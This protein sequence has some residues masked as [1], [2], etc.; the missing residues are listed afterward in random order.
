MSAA[1]RDEVRAFLA[2]ELRAGTF[3]PDVNAWMDG[4]DPAFSRK[5]GE[6]GWIGMT[7]PPDLG[8]GGRSG[9]D[10]FLVTEELLVAGAPVAAHWFADRQVGPQLLRF[11]TREQQEHYLPAIARG[12]CFFAVGMSEPQAGS[13]LAAV[14]TTAVPVDGG[15]LVNGRKLWTSH[16]D[17]DDFMI[18]LCRTSPGHASRHEGLTQLIIDLRAGGVR[19]DPIPGLDGVAHFAEVVLV[20]VFVPEDAVVGRVGEGW[21]Q[22]TAELAFERSGPERFLSVM[23]LLLAATELVWD[24]PAEL[25]TIF[26]ELAAL[27]RLS[28]EVAESLDRGGAPDVEAALV[29]DLGTCFEQRVVD[30]LRLLAGQDDRFDDLLRRARLASPAFTLRGGAT[31]ILRSIIGRMVVAA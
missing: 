9:L 8:G 31:E 3:V 24:D 2:A 17:V 27:R 18:G 10:R 21:R 28:L 19:I 25:G 15:W 22:V 30:G 11:G 12:E 6:R 13:D 23:P 4:H 20:D 26:A 1:L 29:K 16:A 14:A 7:W 5:L